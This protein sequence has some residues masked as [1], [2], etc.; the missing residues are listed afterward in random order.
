M[1][2]HCLVVTSI[3]PDIDASI[4]A[5]LN[6]TDVNIQVAQ[7]LE[8]LLF[9]PENTDVAAIL[10]NY[11]SPED[12]REGAFDAVDGDLTVTE[13]NGN[14]GSDTIYRLR[15]GIERFLIT[16]INNAAATARAQSTIPI[17]CDLLATGSG[18]GVFNHVPGGCNT[19]FLDGH[20][21][22]IRYPGEGPVTPPMAV[23]LGMIVA[24]FGVD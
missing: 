14:G 4:I 23:I 9:A 17:M 13:P 22:F 19:L 20:C 2:R 10:I 3:F 15:E 5:E 8:S 18:V 7:T 12:V 1:R 11:D 24:A 6:S 21:T 16:D